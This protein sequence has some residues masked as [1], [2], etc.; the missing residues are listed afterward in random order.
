MVKVIFC[1]SNVSGYMASCWGALEKQ[2]EIDLFVLAFRART[3]SAFADNLMEG[4]PHHLLD[5]KERQETTLIEKLVLQESPDV[6]VLCGWFHLPYR[7]LVLS[8]RLRDVKCIMCMDT[9]WQGSWKQ[10]LTR[11]ILGSFFQRMDYIV[12]NGERSW[13]YAR[14]LGLPLRNIASLGMYGVDYENLSNLLSQREHSTWPRSF[15]FVGRYV[16]VKAIDI[17]VAAY[18]QYRQNVHEPWN[19]VCC[20]QG[21][22]ISY[23]DSQPG[24]DNQGF[25]QPDEMKMHWLNAGAFVLPSRFEPWGAALVEAAAAGLPLICTQACG[26]SVEVVRSG[27]NGLVVPPDDVDSLYQAMMRIHDN[28]DELPEWG[29]RSQSLAAPYSTTQWARYWINFIKIV[30]TLRSE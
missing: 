1:W 18:R 11:W 8:P 22:L 27:Y 7:Q 26:S 28:Y 19:L 14:R 5:L 15:L 6:L 29:K 30:Q 16:H 21:E 17:L 23:L 3:D 9:P 10:Y 20:G 12:V 4:I 13:Q 24:I 25:I 2:S